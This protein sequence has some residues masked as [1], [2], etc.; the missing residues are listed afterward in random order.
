MWGQQKTTWDAVESAGW[1]A[2]SLGVTTSVQN[3]LLI[4]PEAGG[5]M[6][7]IA[8]ISHTSKVMLRILQARL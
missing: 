1:A 8:L 2:E 7:T 4:Q 3:P 6:P 5:I